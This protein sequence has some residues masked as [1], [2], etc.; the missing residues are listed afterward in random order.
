M[1]LE[2]AH[3][4]L[5]LGAVRVTGPDALDFLQAQLSA[6]LTALAPQ[7]LSPAAWCNPD[8]RAEFTL[9]IARMDA[10]LLLAIPADRLDALTR[11]LRRF[12]IGR[13]IAIEP[14]RP[15]GPADGGGIQLAFDPR[16]RLVEHDQEPFAPLPDA[17]LAADAESGMPWLTAATADRYLPQMLG[18][19]ALGGLSFRKGCYPGQEVIARVHYRGR[20]TRRTARFRCSADVPPAPGSEFTIGDGTGQVLYAATGTDGAIVGLAVIPAG[21]EPDARGH[22]QAHTVLDFHD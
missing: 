8:G 17:W 21:T 19:E 18:L 6:D 14:P 11:K 13:R 9:L 16:R 3:A 10:D 1:A 4:S 12:S 7:I 15:L 2:S 5:A 20:L 22:V